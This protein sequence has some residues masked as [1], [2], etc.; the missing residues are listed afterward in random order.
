MDSHG[1]VDHAVS[2]FGELPFLFKLRKG[3]TVEY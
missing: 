3:L 2:V 1:N